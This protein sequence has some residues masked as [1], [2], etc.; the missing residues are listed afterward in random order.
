MRLRL[1]ACMLEESL[2]VSIANIRKKTFSASTSYPAQYDP[3]IFLYSRNHCK[4]PGDGVDP[5]DIC[6]ILPPSSVIRREDL[7]GLGFVPWVEP[8]EQPLVANYM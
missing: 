4:R 2:F 8:G 5:V 3:L 1:N 7:P 6:D